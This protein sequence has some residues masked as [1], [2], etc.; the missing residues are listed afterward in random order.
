MLF[1]GKLAVEKNWSGIKF[2]IQAFFTRSD[3]RIIDSVAPNLETWFD[4][5]IDGGI[6]L[7][8]YIANVKRLIDAIRLDAHAMAHVAARLLVTLRVWPADRYAHDD[9]LKAAQWCLTWAEDRRLA[10]FNACLA[11]ADAK[12][13]RDV[14]PL[15]K[16]A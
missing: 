15:L 3:N 10:E 12:W 6:S 2:A 14:Q 11:A 9:A 16:A 1:T 8:A 5:Y 7:D 13:T 4:S